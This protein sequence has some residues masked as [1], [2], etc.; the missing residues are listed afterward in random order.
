MAGNDWCLP[1]SCCQAICQPR[2][3]QTSTKTA[4]QDLQTPSR[5]P[6]HSPRLSHFDD[7]S[8]C[9]PFIYLQPWQGCG[10]YKT[11]LS[12]LS[13]VTGIVTFIGISK[14]HT[15]QTWRERLTFGVSTVLFLLLLICGD[16]ESNPGPK[17]HY[18]VSFNLCMH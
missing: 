16:V 4:F 18:K 9:E 6:H 5:E 15:R 11:R 3:N 1:T 10:T 17:D 14:E 2:E 8:F 7:L 13:R 12:Y